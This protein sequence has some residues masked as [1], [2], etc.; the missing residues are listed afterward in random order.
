[1]ATTP[2]KTQTQDSKKSLDLKP[3]LK[4]DLKDNHD[5]SFLEKILKNS[6]K[7]DSKTVLDELTRGLEACNPFNPILIR[8]QLLKKHKE[9]REQMTESDI[10]EVNKQFLGDKEEQSE[11]E[12]DKIKAEWKSRPN[13]KNPD[14]VLALIESIAKEIAATAVEKEFELKDLLEA[15]RKE[16]V[17]AVEKSK[18]SNG[19]EGKEITEDEAT[20]LEDKAR[21]KTIELFYNSTFKLIEL[22]ESISAPLEIILTDLMPIACVLCVDLRGPNKDTQIGNQITEKYGYDML[23]DLYGLYSQTLYGDDP[24]NPDNKEAEKSVSIFS[25]VG[26]FFK[27]AFKAAAVKAQNV[28]ISIATGGQVKDGLEGEKE[29]GWGRFKGWSPAKGYLMYQYIDDACRILDSFM[30]E[31]GVKYFFKANPTEVFGQKCKKAIRTITSPEIKEAVVETNDQ[32][33]SKPKPATTPWVTVEMA[34]TPKSG[35]TRSFLH[36]EDRLPAAKALLGVIQCSFSGVSAPRT[37]RVDADIAKLCC[38]CY[39]ILTGKAVPDLKVLSD[40][41]SADNHTGNHQAENGKPKANEKN[42]LVTE[43]KS[44]AVSLDGQSKQKQ[45][46]GQS[47]QVGQTLNAYKAAVDNAAP[48]STLGNKKSAPVTDKPAQNTAAKKA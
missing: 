31:A 16:V 39:Q 7:L 29:K 9:L 44:D 35:E 15:S 26:G 14:E 17:E 24:E 36:F 28:L 45:A 6:V 18:D 42:G 8:I 21:A 22:A 33:K 4:T 46:E 25:Q 47:G 48:L 43:T 2:N 3:E 1:M 41:N 27:S 30:D 20:K 37:P 38:D 40:G 34:V 11:G 13:I 12:I 10:T 5:I 23:R 19:T 32:A